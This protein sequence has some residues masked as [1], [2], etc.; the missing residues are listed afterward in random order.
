MGKK[1][2]ATYIAVKSETFERRQRER[3]YWKNEL[4]RC[5]RTKDAERDGGEKYT[6]IFR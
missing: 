4:E 3:P 1:K 6:Y 2:K 5:G